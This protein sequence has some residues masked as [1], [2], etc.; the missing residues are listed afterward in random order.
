MHS[1][2]PVSGRQTR[3]PKA[4]TTIR[5]AVPAD[6]PAIHAIVEAAYRD[7]SATGWTTEADILAGK[8]T[9]PEAIDEQISRPDSM[10]LVACDRGDDTIL[11]TCYIEKQDGHGYFGMFAVDPMAQ[12]QGI[13][14]ALFDAAER[15]ATDDWQLDRMQMT[16]I[17]QRDDLIAWYEAIGYVRTGETEPFPGADTSTPLIDDIHMVVLEKPLSLA[18]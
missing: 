12:S 1:S 13:G 16:V 15:I 17:A 7:Q 3:P 14:R 9:R 18:R 11:G 6:A 10:T 4:S 2:R 8:R 5:R